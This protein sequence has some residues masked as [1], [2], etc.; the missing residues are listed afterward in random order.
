MRQSE[1]TCLKCQNF[2]SGDCHLEP[3]S[4]RILAPEGHW[5]SRGV[6]PE[7]SER[8]GAYEPHYWGEWEKTPY[9]LMLNLN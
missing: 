2:D 4:I 6:W 8:F 7:W 5:C 9:Q 3:V 1:M